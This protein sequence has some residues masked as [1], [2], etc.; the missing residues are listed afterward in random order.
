MDYREPEHIFFEH[1]PSYAPSNTVGSAGRL[2]NQI[3]RNIVCSA[4]AQ[5][6]NLKFVYGFHEKI[7][8]LGIELYTNGTHNY[9]N[10]IVIKDDDFFVLLKQESLTYNLNTCAAFFQNQDIAN[11]IRQQLSEPSQKLQ[12]INKNIYRHRYEK[13]NDVFV[14]VRLD[15]AT[16][17]NH[18]FEYYDLVLSDLVFDQGFISSDTIDHPLCQL[19]IKK[20]GLIPIQMDEVRTIMLAST[21]K[22]LLLSGGTFSW[23][24]GVLGWFST[25]FYPDPQCQQQWHGDIFG[26]SDW[27]KINIHDK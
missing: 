22:Y 27:N 19:L 5:K 26:F 24:I 13:N 9:P 7:S 11:F 4:L 1:T 25:V 12:I 15:D 8:E 6:H 17:Y 18:G 2:C 3:I 21:C 16:H 23:T 14:H 20:H 10:T